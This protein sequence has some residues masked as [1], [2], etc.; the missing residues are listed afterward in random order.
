RE[1]SRALLSLKQRNRRVVDYAIEFRTLAAD[2]GWNEAAI[3]DAFV[4]GLTEKLNDITIKNCY[5]L[6]VISSAFELLQQAKIFTKL[7]LR[8]TYHLVRIREGDEGSTLLM[9]TTNIWSYL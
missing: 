9:D 6:P 1:A 7:D 8:N 4:S 5:P 2:S 3:N